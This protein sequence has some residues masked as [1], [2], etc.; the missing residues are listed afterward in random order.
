MMGAT[1]VNPV[2]MTV[3]EMDKMLT[4][5]YMGKREEK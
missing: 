1:K 4:Q 5:V 3:E 2:K